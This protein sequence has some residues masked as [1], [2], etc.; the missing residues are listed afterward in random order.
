[1]T[2]K[3][4]YPKTVEVAGE[5]YQVKV[6][7]ADGEIRS[8]RLLGY[9]Q[10]VFFETDWTGD[11][12]ES[13]VLAEIQRVTDVFDQRFPHLSHCLVSFKIEMV[14]GLSDS[15]YSDAHIDRAIND[16]AKFYGF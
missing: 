4:M 6:N 15:R 1:M 12:T 7:K 11:F 3:S 2:T 10:E 9:A 14:D 8:F 13:D 5:K 16:T